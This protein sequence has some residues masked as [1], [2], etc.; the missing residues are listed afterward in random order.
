[1][2]ILMMTNTYLPHVGGVARSVELTTR[3]LRSRGHRVLVVAPE[4]E[5][6]PSEENDVVR[7]PAIQHFNGS[8]FSVK[9]PVPGLLKKHL[10][11]FN[12]EIVHAHHPFLLGS[13]AVRVATQREIPLVFTYHT[14]YEQYTHYVPGNSPRMKQFAIQLAKGYCNLCDHVIA[15]SESIMEILRQRGVKTHII[16]IPTGI[17]TEKFRRGDGQAFRSRLGIPEKAFLVGYVGRLAP[18]K[19]LEFLATS[20]RTFMSRNTDSYFLVVGSGPSSRKIRDIF[21]TGGIEDRLYLAGTLENEELVNAYHSMDV[22][23]FAS[24]S[25]TQ[26]MVL[27]EA[28]A[29]G[30]PVVALDAPGVREVVRDGKN[31]KLLFQDSHELFATSLEEIYVLKEKDIQLFRDNARATSEELSLSRC[32]DRLME[33]YAGVAK[34]TTAIRD[35]EFHFWESAMDQL[36]VEWELIRNIAEAAAISFQKENRTGQ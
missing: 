10:D 28:M 17:I 30:L 16:S 21:R 9:V 15:P 32:V 29:T 31:G 24:R 13:T 26:G 2:N 6:M 1:M 20:A 5:G 22:F 18:E 8:D 33:V 7:I 12:P 35:K 11:H 23:I 25:E 27:A 34:G 19:N 36:K 3:E 14:N 4:F